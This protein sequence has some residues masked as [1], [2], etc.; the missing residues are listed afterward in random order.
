MVAEASGISKGLVYRY[1][2][3]KEQLF[4]AAVER[5]VDQLEGRMDEVLDQPLD[6][7]DK[8]EAATIAYLQFFEDHPDLVELFVHE[9]AE[10]RDRHQPIYFERGCKNEGR[11]RADLLQLMS[12]GR[13]RRVSPDR[14]MNVM[15][16]LVYGTVF[17]N[18]FSGRERSSEQQA[19]EMIDVVFNGIL[20][21]SE[22]RKRK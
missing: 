11:W 20:T 15:G 4:L 16:D 8:M 22:R 1:F 5:G 17:A 6:L 12:D 2:P 10:F 18:Y 9:R 7:L 19:R 14:I 13:V 3:N 21:D